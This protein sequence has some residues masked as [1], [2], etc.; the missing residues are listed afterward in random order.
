MWVWN[1]LARVWDTKVCVVRRE[2]QALHVC[3]VM[4]LH[5][6][7]AVGWGHCPELQHQWFWSGSAQCR[8]VWKLGK[9]TIYVLYRVD[10]GQA[11]PWG[12]SLASIIKWVNLKD[13]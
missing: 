8:Q 12:Q 13:R 6:T 9:G 11:V 7:S 2:A 4:H 1:L 3:S 10:R 5:G